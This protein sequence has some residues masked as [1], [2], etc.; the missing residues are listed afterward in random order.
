[1]MT[2]SSG[3]PHQF[4][5][6]IPM[7][8]IV[9]EIEALRKEISELRQLVSPRQEWYDLREVAAL[10][11]VPYGTMTARPWIKPRGGKPDGIIGGRCKWR[12]DTV[13]RWL[14][15]TDED[16]PEPNEGSDRGDQK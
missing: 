13:M 1:M 11:G 5:V 15:E 8:E 6:T 4:E 16:L 12:H 7:E 14:A 2:K 10:K 9:H 3:V